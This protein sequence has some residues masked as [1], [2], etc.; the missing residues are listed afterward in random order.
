[1][2]A[3]RVDPVDALTRSAIMRAVKNRRVKS[4]ELALR[5]RLVSAGVRGWRMYGEDLPGTPDFVFQPEKLA[6][7]VHGCFWHGCPHCYRRPRSNRK[8]WDQKIKGNRSRDACVTAKLQRTGWSVLRLWEHSLDI[9]P[10]VVAKILKAR[11]HC[12]QTR[13]YRK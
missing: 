5:A 10:H 9:G 7:F 1:M 8:Y 13:R 12:R 6:I 4:T 2:K 3:H 11:Q